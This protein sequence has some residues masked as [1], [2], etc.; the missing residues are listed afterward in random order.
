VIG[1]ILKS[2]SL[3][4]SYLRQ[5][6]DD[7]PDDM[8]TA[9]LAGAINHPAW[10]TGHLIYSAEAIGGEIGLTPWL[11]SD[12]AARF[13]TGSI[14][15]SDR[16]AYPSKDI[17]LGSLTDA[18]QRIRNRLMRIGDDGMM[19]PLPD[20]RHRESFPTI[21]HAVLHILTTH[22]AIHIGQLTVW[23]RVLGYG[24]LEKPFV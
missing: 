23:R 19:E 22:A 15:V 6:V 11:P 8:F 2:Y 14:P 10:V 16:Q 7:V 21:G 5:L 3:S 13:G 1:A 9:Q 12:W 18:E 17:L 24:P 4:L 20:V